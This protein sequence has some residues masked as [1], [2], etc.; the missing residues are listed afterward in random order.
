MSI[1]DQERLTRGYPQKFL[2]ISPQPLKPNPYLKRILNFVP[3]A[4]NHQTT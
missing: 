1:A 3:I 2:I 4:S